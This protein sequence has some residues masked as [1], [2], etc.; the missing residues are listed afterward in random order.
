MTTDP[1]VIE[2]A[3][4]IFAKLATDPDWDDAYETRAQAAACDDDDI[5][6][7]ECIDLARACILKWLEQEAANG[8]SGEFWNY[9]DEY[10]A[11]C[12]QAAKE[13]SGE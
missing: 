6:Q 11:M 12:A 8:A 3:K 9:R 5:S 1:R 7:E 13:I 2:C 10:R 4:A